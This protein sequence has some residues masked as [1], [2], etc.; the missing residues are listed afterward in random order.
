MADADDVLK[1]R[2]DPFLRDYLTE[3]P[4]PLAFE[5]SWECRILAQQSFVRPILDVGCGEGLFA[6]ILF[7]GQIDAGIDPNGRELERAGRLGRYR[8]L[9][10]CTGDRIPKPDG[11]YRTIFSNSVLEHIP[12]LDGVLRELFRLLAPGGQMFVTVPSHRFDHYSVVHTLLRSIGLS[13]L[14]ERYRKFF[15][16]FW[17]HH[18]YYDPAGWKALFT[19]HGFQVEQCFMYGSK[20]LCLLNDFLI[21]FSLPSMV[22]KKAVNRWTL[23]PRLRRFCLA[24]LAASA[25]GLAKQVI[26]VPE[27]GLVF[28]KLGKSSQAG[29]HPLAA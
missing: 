20:N 8:E 7:E 6:H 9:I 5:R 3:A 17:Q 15:N 23:L 24:P 28:L 25:E 21:P 16:R 12:D 2:P 27:G 22:L 19:R 26:D 18:H 10:Q 11:S 13:S 4:F 14:A 1:P 29:S